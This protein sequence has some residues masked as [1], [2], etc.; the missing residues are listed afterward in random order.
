[1]V[2]QGDWEAPGF[3]P[4]HEGAAEETHRRWGL[5]GRCASA[6]ARRTEDVEGPKDV[7]RTSG[8]KDEV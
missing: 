2:E 4:C 3:W 8:S 6:R 1:M 5:G 7:E